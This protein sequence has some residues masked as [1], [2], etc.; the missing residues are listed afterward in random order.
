MF[1]NGVVYSVGED[2][3]SV[4]WKIL[5]LNV[6][7]KLEMNAKGEGCVFLKLEN[8]DFGFFFLPGH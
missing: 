1:L 3:I 2:F 4:E 8:E 7:G 6:V 5:K